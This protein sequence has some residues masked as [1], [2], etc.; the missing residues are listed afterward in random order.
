[1]ANSCLNYLAAG[2]PGAVNLIFMRYKE[3]S[4]GIKVQNKEGDIEYGVSKEASKSAIM[5]TALSR[6]I[7]PIPVL[8]FPAVVN[9]V[10]ESLRLWPKSFF[11]SKSL[12][13]TL[14]AFSLTFALPMSVALF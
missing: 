12:E 6:L 10:L 4:E 5:Q 8:F 1:M 2:V 11:L 3:L 13:L 9:F 7:L 14:C